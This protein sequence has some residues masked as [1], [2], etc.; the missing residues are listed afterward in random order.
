MAYFC[1]CIKKLLH[2]LS[3]TNPLLVLG[4]IGTTGLS[5]AESN[6]SPYGSV[7]I[8]S[9]Q[10][11]NGGLR[12]DFTSRL[13]FDGGVDYQFNNQHLFISYQAQR[14]D[15]G[16]DSVGDIQAYS[17]IDEDDFSRIYE[18]YYQYEGANWLIKFGKNDA[19][20]D[21]AVADPSGNFINSSMGFSPTIVGFPTYPSPALSLIGSL[22][23]TDALQV[24]AAVFAAKNTTNFA[25]QFYV[26]ELAYQ[27]SEY[28]LIKIGFWHDTNTY[29]SLKEFAEPSQSES[30]YY[31]IAQSTL[32]NQH[33]FN[34]EQVNWYLQLG[35]ADELAS[36]IE[37]HVGSG[38]EISQPFS[39]AGQGMGLGLSHV[40]LSQHINSSNGSETAIETYYFWSVTEHFI[41]KPDL[42]YVITPS[43]DNQIANALIFTLRLELSY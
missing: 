17:N 7:T 12:Q 39:Q 10:V 40:K 28:S 20:V 18:F 19:N 33:W 3:R 43:G 29:D 38:I 4:L 41:V 23:I 24:S 5:Y 6:F 37:W 9:S 34:S 2:K 15:N 32:P 42:Q 11:L 35:H 1:F 26:T 8:D 14:G 13:L 30:G 31:L 36:E 25:E 22:T 21:F 16:S 27:L